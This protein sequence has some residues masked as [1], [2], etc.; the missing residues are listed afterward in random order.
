MINLLFITK[1][2]K[3]LGKKKFTELF[4]LKTVKAVGEL[5]LVLDFDPC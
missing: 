5:T 3:Q 2:A 1:L 4:E